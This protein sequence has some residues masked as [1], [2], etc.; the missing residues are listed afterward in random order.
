[1]HVHTRNTRSLCLHPSPT[2]CLDRIGG[3][4]RETIIV[5]TLDREASAGHCATMKDSAKSEHKRLAII[6][7][8]D[9]I[10]I[11]II[12]TFRIHRID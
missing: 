7:T 11:M 1:M 9:H 2:P 6:V 5:S 3:V 4:A 12:I 10:I 8:S